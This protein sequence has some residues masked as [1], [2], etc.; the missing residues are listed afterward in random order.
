M[1]S[2]LCLSLDSVIL[3]GTVLF[4]FLAPSLRSVASGRRLFLITLLD[5]M[6]D[7]FLDPTGRPMA[8][9]SNCKSL[10]ASE[11]FRLGWSL[12]YEQK[13]G[14]GEENAGE[15]RLGIKQW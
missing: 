1:S 14:T 10:N 3:R 4:G 9:L 5:W 7:T 8:A 2:T 15:S 11:R 6:L 12:L 13:S